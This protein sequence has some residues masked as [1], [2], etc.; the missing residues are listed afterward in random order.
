MKIELQP[1]TASGDRR[2]YLVV[3]YYRVAVPGTSAVN[4]VQHLG[5]F[6]DDELCYLADALAPLRTRPS[7]P[8]IGDLVELDLGGEG[9]AKPGTAAAAMEGA[10]AL[11]DALHTHTA[12]IPAKAD[13]DFSDVDAAGTAGVTQVDAEHPPDPM[14]KGE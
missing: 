9:A 2:T 11:S 6:A 3:E 10:K 13:K 7:R 8:R 12:E 14:D 4:V 5:P 1:T